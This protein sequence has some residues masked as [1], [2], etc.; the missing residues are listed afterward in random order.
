MGP[1]EMYGKKKN[2]IVRNILLVF[3]VIAFWACVYGMSRLVFKD[4]KS[5]V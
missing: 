2:N 5:V 3:G 1:E 4:R